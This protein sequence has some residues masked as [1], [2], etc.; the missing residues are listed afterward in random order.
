MKAR[1]PELR[2]IP[3]FDSGR[4]KL[5]LER[6]PFSTVSNLTMSKIPVKSKTDSGICYSDFDQT[7]RFNDWL[8]FLGP[9]PNPRFFLHFR[10]ALGKHMGRRGVRQQRQLA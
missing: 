5:R 1:Q 4:W 3:Q 7:L 2:G 10:S 9:T 8:R 6:V